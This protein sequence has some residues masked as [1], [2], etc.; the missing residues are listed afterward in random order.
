MRPCPGCGK[1]LGP[2]AQHCG[3]RECKRRYL[4]ERRKIRA[5]VAVALGLCRD[6]GGGKQ[7]RGT[8]LCYQCTL[9]RRHCERERKRRQLLER[10]ALAYVAAHRR[11]VQKSRERRVKA[12]TERIS[13]GLEPVKGRGYL[14]VP[15]KQDTEA[16]LEL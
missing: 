10:D 9:Y 14:I 16:P 13:R 4:A 1:P 6:C 7:Y 15:E 12:Q 5:Q 3:D 2:H 8:R 11:L